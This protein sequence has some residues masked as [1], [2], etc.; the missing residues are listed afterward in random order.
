MTGVSYGGLA[1][2]WMGYRLPHIFGNVIAQAPS[3]WWGPGFDTTK[4]A[5]LAVRTRPAG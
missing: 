2:M 1:A 5:A 4:A 3:L